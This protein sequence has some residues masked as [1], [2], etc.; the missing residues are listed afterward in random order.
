MLGRT[1]LIGLGGAIVLTIGGGTAYATIAGGPVDSGGVVHGCYT[2]Q[3]L[4]GSHVFVLQ[5]AGT[6][7]PKGTTPISWSQ[8]G[9]AGP[10]G[11]PGIQGPTGATGATGMTG[12]PGATGDTGPAGPTGATGPAGATGAT[13]PQGPAGPGSGIDSGAITINDGCVSNFVSGPDA[14]V[15]SVTDYS[16]NTSECEISIPGA[17]TYSMI[18]Q[19]DGSTDTSLVLPLFTTQGHSQ[20]FVVAIIQGS[21]FDTGTLSWEA[22]PSS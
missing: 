17:G 20:Y 16:G 22:I 18:A 6:N 10:Q 4:N 3:A 11:P 13:G 14:A 21:S 1:V 12:A 9:P 19:V 5:D 7:C 15:V 8:T 2:T